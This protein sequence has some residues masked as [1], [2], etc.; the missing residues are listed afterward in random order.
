VDQT[1]GAG[2]GAAGSALSDVADGDELAVE[3]VDPV[4]ARPHPAPRRTRAVRP[5]PATIRDLGLGWG[6]TRGI[7]VNVSVALARVR[8]GV[9]PS[10]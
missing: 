10:H 6:P 3:P 2:G 1:T 8:D 5:T 9:A 4:D 7:G